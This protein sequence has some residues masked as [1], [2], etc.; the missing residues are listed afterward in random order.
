MK[1]LRKKELQ[2]GYRAICSDL[3]HTLLMPDKSISP[4]TEKCLHILMERGVELIPCTGRAFHSLPASVTGFSGIR[5]VVVSNGAAIYDL[6][7]GVPVYSLFLEESFAGS[8]FE[9][10]SAGED[11]MTYECF[12]GGQ[13]YTSRAYYNNPADFGIPGEIERKY[14]QSTRYP[15]E[16]IRRFI[17]EHADRL[18]ALDIITLP[19]NR[20]RILD[21]VRQAFPEIYVTS[22]IPH[23]IEISDVMSGKHNAM[24]RMAEYLGIG[25]EEII[26]FG[27]GD[28][29]SDMLKTAGLGLAVANAT[30]L[31]KRS[32]D[33]VIGASRDEGVADYLIGL[34]QLDVVD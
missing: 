10:L 19:R 33:L 6:T 17:L 2:P 4:K 14:I 13:A 3:D 20:D 27:D 15:V 18:D 29:D 34:Y 25:T 31:C 28:N 23:L 16:D 32:A 11:V 8:L 21:D 24:K 12:V 9:F 1:T 30:D 26:A 7:R 5:Y 22:S